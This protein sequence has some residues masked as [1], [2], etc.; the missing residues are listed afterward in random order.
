MLFSSLLSAKAQ[1][2]FLFIYLFLNL[3]KFLNDNFGFLIFK[4]KLITKKK[5]ADTEAVFYH[6]MMYHCVEGTDVHLVVQQ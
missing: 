5:H 1:K 6:A 4:S 2:G 3:F